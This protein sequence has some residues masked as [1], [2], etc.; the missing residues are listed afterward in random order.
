MSS[1]RRRLTLWRGRDWHA[2]GWVALR[3]G[4]SCSVPA[5]RPPQAAAA[6][7]LHDMAGWIREL[8]E[9]ASGFTG[10]EPALW[11]DTLYNASVLFWRT[12]YGAVQPCSV[13]GR[14]LT[15]RS[16]PL[17]ATGEWALLLDAAKLLYDGLCLAAWPDWGWRGQMGVLTAKCLAETGDRKAARGT[18]TKLYTMLRS[19]QKADSDSSVRLQLLM[20]V[21]CGMIDELE[22][23]NPVL[24]AAATLHMMLA[25][26]EPLDAAALE[27]VVGLDDKLLLIKGVRSEEDMTQ[28]DW[29]A[30]TD[31][32][33]RQEALALRV[34]LGN[35]LL[36]HG[37][38]LDRVRQIAG[39]ASI[40]TDGDTAGVGGDILACRMELHAIDALGAHRA[41]T[42]PVVDRRL[43]AVDG[44]LRAMQRAKNLRSRFSMQEAACLAWNASLPLMQPNLRHQIRPALEMAVDL[45]QASGS[46]MFG[47]VAGCHLELARI[48]DDA[49]LAAHAERHL[50]LAADCDA[51][52]GDVH[53]D[54]IAR[55][56]RTVRARAVADR[57]DD[58]PC[59]AALE[60]AHSL[61]AR[62][63]EA[64]DGT[65]CRAALVE[66]GRA[67]APQLFGDDIIPIVLVPFEC[68]S[69][70]LRASRALQFAE[71]D[72]LATAAADDPAA[73][74]HL[75]FWDSFARAA[76]KRLV[77]DVAYAAG[78]VALA[79]ARRRCSSA[80]ESDAEADAT[81]REAL[82]TTAELH[83]ILSEI[84]VFL[85]R[86][87][88]L[89][90]GDVPADATP[91][92][93]AE[94]A[95]QQSSTALEGFVEGARCGAALGASWITVNAAVYIW[96]HGIAL[97]REGRGHVLCS[98][99]REVHRALAPLCAAPAE[100][101][102]SSTAGGDP[103]V[104]VVAAR[105][106]NLLA[107]SE[108][109]GGGESESGTGIQLCEDALAF[110]A[111]VSHADSAALIRT[112]VR[113]LCA[114]G[115]PIECPAGGPVL[116]ALFAVTA[117]EVV[118]DAAPG[119]LPELDEMCRLC[120]EC[121][122]RDG[123]RVMSSDNAMRLLARAA[124]VC[125]GAQA[126][127]L[128][129]ECAGHLLELA[130]R[131]RGRGAVP[132][133]RR[134]ADAALSHVACCVLG[135]AAEARIMDSSDES[136]Q[137]AQR[138]RTLGHFLRASE[139]GRAAGDPSRVALA[140]QYV[141][142]VAL[143]FAL[144]AMTNRLVL[145]PLK[146]ALEDLRRTA[147]SNKNPVAVPL[148]I[149]MY[150][151]AFSVLAEH[152]EWGQG[153]ALV[154][155][156][157]ESLP[158]ASR[159]FLW[160]FRVIFKSKLGKDVGRELDR[161]QDKPPDERCDFW[162][163]LS[164]VEP[165]MEQRLE[166]LH[167]AADCVRGVRGHETRY[168]D[169][170]VQLSRW[171][172]AHGQ[173]RDSDDCVVLL[174][175]ANDV[176]MALR[177]ESDGLLGAA[178][179]SRTAELLVR[180][181]T[182]LALIQVEPELRRRHMLFAH[183]YVVELWSATLEILGARATEAARRAA[184]AAEGEGGR[185]K[186]G[187]KGTKGAEPG[188]AMPAIPTSS[189]GWANFELPPHALE[190]AAEG[191]EV[192]PLRVPEPELTAHYADVLVAMLEQAGMHHMAIQP[193]LLAFHIHHPDHG[194]A[195]SRMRAMVRA[196]RLDALIA[197]LRIER[198]GETW[199][200][201]VGSALPS[202]AER[203]AVR[204][205]VYQT[206]QRREIQ[207]ASGTVNDDDGGGASES[208]G[209]GPV[210]HPLR[211]ADGW[212]EQLGVLVRA[213][214][215]DDVAQLAFDLDVA[216][217]A[218]RDSRLAARTALAA[219]RL[220]MA[221]D[222]P[223]EAIASLRSILQP[224]GEGPIEEAA[225][226]V[227]VTE[228]LGQAALLQTQQQ[229]LQG[230]TVPP[231]SAPRPVLAAAAD[232]FSALAAAHF[233]GRHTFL[234]CGAVLR[235]RE[236]EALVLCID[237]PAPVGGGLEA[238]ATAVEI[239]RGASTQLLDLG[240]VFA[241]STAVMRC[242]ATLVHQLPAAGTAPFRRV[243]DDLLAVFDAV[244]RALRDLVAA[245]PHAPTEV[246]G[247]GAVQLPAATLLARVLTARADVEGRLY[248]LECARAVEQER[249]DAN[250]PTIERIIAEY[251]RDEDALPVD[252]AAWEQR[253]R[254]AGECAVSRL[255]GVRSM[256]PRQAET[257]IAA[258]A[259]LGRVLRCSAE[260]A[261]GSAF[262]GSAR[263]VWC[264]QAGADEGPAA[265]R[266]RHEALADELTAALGLW[267]TTWWW[268]SGRWY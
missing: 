95:A 118:Q 160:A 13:L 131:P 215:F 242:H 202:D 113:L 167:K 80:D 236:A 114:V 218:F 241:C 194:C 159:G 248:V 44:C 226:W 172:Y 257:A 74:E 59:E 77:C 180:I 229:L 154:D 129:A 238:V 101:D 186:S 11:G 138:H 250:P 181:H 78:T 14:L 166:A 34:R 61:I 187:K 155:H 124:L 261:R 76:R 147:P 149:K 91:P 245:M 116:R 10:A 85:L 112:Y 171:L 255:S 259:L 232:S 6:R 1:C 75:A 135:C 3:R 21:E 2:A 199:A 185:K 206:L 234:T 49:G 178:T 265:W 79:L 66:A 22:H 203:D 189:T 230:N 26:D 109:D 103:R 5:E 106:A 97:V 240:E 217:S 69:E 20:D 46:V 191:E 183:H 254:V 266:P 133:E 175:S 150:N 64:V 156:A 165:H 110:L 50:S 120:G 176:I 251:V 87:D 174:S 246:A 56:R 86:E 228:T 81:R 233:A 222:R 237:A 268:W 117:R 130:G 45:L 224:M 60:L 122:G 235:V 158:R 83:Y 179:K 96:N 102:A 192:T 136:Q 196:T 142:N 127:D 72:M 12:W 8:C 29:S 24:D 123:P 212:A 162:C 37:A 71:L 90:L 25:S 33:L 105:I 18:I 48:A 111:D 15:R 7:P 264:T 108:L 39:H 256:Q 204:V 107:V 36:D 146:T 143:P 201:G 200:H 157:F 52:A 47:L 30:A 119:A 132:L 239:L 163:T 225:F 219:A 55:L 31:G 137:A 169:M 98:P 267:G 153:L 214:R 42:Q 125:T 38:H 144:H 258:G 28:A 210:L 260:R 182:M 195:P 164:R 19:Q 148:R 252:Q 94:W 209:A 104:L 82:R 92:S 27:R 207:A 115:R 62:A 168:A 35:V 40:A 65:A 262:R 67:L 54:S 173:G 205:Q 213:G 16:R 63:A 84:R 177:F 43:S 208:E 88:G 57:P 145:P 23:T 53:A 51:R 243:A 227:E 89:Q 4:S 126:F 223:A 216:A 193:L 140:A 68:G 197:E 73:A 99:L 93:Y 170:L 220:A 211:E 9:V 141:W 190:T 188:P 244:E 184:D 247:D 128:G 100:T 152:G 263:G 17:M 70:K 139:H 231:E 161:L 41:Y 151:L 58:Q 134:R 249:L 32:P 121:A 221:R 198:A 253:L